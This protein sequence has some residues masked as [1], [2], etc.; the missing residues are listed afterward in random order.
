MKSQNVETEE[1]FNLM[2]YNDD[3]PIIQQENEYVNQNSEIAS[4]IR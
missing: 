1:Y 4:H 3:L 2:N